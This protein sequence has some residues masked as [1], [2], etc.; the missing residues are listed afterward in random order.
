[1]A[2]HG[3]C[4]P[5]FDLIPVMGNCCNFCSGILRDVGAFYEGVRINVSEELK[6]SEVA[7]GRLALL[8]NKQRVT[9]A[10][11]QTHCDPREL[12]VQAKENKTEQ[13]LFLTWNFKLEHSRH[14]QNVFVCMNVRQFTWLNCVWR[15]FTS[16]EQRDQQRCPG[17]PWAGN[18]PA[19]ERIATFPS[20]IPVIASGWLISPLKP[21]HALRHCISFSRCRVTLRPFCT[22]QCHFIF[23]NALNETNSSFKHMNILCLHITIL[24]IFFLHIF[25]FLSYF[26]FIEQK[27]G[28]LFIRQYHQWGNPGEMT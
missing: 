23:S 27:R 16:G 14:V 8:H 13:W 19:A 7:G 5:T 28:K 3:P 18:R 4:S 17:A 22:G 26:I 25:M 21:Q 1:M 24:T 12:L 9:S 11:N 10:S 2:G 6:N 20:F 15:V